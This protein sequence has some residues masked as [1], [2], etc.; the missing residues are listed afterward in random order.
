MWAPSSEITYNIGIFFPNLILFYLETFFYY[1]FFCHFCSIGTF[2]LGTWICINRLSFKH[3]YTYIK[4][5]YIWIITHTHKHTHTYKITHTFCSLIL[6]PRFF[7]F[8]VY[9]AWL[10]FLHLNFIALNSCSSAYSVT[11][12]FTSQIWFMK[13]D[14][15][16]TPFFFWD[17]SIFV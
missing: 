1:S 15:H 13:W 2:Y 7:S 17:L 11:L 12:N 6:F 4:V 16:L 8:T 9:F 3:T 10:F 14:Y 5:A